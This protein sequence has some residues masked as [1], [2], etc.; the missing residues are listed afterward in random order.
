MNTNSRDG[1]MRVD[2]NGGSSLNY[3]PNSVSGP[4]EDRSKTMAPIN[5]QNGVM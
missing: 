1:F 4:V 3:E 2:G 5:V